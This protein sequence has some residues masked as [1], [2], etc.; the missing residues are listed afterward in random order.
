MT[1]DDLQNTKYVG[2]VGDA[3]DGGVRCKGCSLDADSVNDWDIEELEW[4]DVG[5]T[6]WNTGWVTLYKSAA[7]PAR[8][9]M[10]YVT[11]DRSESGTI[12]NSWCERVPSDDRSCTGGGLANS[13]YSTLFVCHTSIT[14][15]QNP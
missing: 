14:S 5:L 6:T 8:Y 13:I 3:S 7:D 9:D 2:W 15:M 12:T 11:D 1:C 4:K 10:T